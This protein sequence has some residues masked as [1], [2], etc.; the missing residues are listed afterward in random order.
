MNNK[1]H[2]NVS[3]DSGRCVVM[4]LIASLVYLKIDRMSLVKIFSSLIILEV[5]NNPTDEYNH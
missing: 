3:G 5:P 4:A 1:S 2:R